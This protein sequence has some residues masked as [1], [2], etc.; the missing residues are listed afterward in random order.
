MVAQALL[1]ILDDPPDFFA[2]R[3]HQASIPSGTFL[4]GGCLM[5]CF[6]K[7]NLPPWG[8]WIAAG[9]TD[10]VSCRSRSIEYG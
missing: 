1:A 6:E 7:I 3:A 5:V 9:E 10:E 4:K 2:H 8:R